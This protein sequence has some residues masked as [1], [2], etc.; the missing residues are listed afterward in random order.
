[1]IKKIV[2]F[3]KLPF[4]RK[5]QYLTMLFNKLKT[6][7]WY[8][9]RMLAC[10][11]NTVIN[12]PLFWT[13]EN[14]SCGNN[15]YIWPGSRFEAVR[16]YK[17]ANY[18]PKLIIGDRTSFQQHCHITFA[19][20]LIIGH[21]VTISF[22]VSIQDTDHEYSKIDTNI[23]NQDLTVKRTKIGDYCF[24]GSGAKIQAGTILGKQCIVG[25]NAVVRGYFPDYCVIVGV[26]GRI[27]KRYNIDTNKWEKTDK[28][29][30]FI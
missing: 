9:S 25:T 8:K 7:L 23:L 18:S 10:G 6:S 28:K 14:I 17:D 15:V 22:G 12:N 26:P 20:K 11:S 21:D 29:G 4:S 13:P 1:M 24:I 30:D 3:I 27:I 5:N 16:K 19:N 2:K